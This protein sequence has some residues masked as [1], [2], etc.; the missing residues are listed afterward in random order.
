[1]LIDKTTTCKRKSKYLC[2]SCE[3]GLTTEDRIVITRTIRDNVRK[4]YDLCKD[5]YRK[6]RIII[7]K[8][9]LKKGDKE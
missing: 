4:K 7:E 5:C 9:K 2:D 3:K 6:I 8:H 1:M